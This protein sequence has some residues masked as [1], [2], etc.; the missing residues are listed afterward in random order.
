M[1]YIWI[2]NVALLNVFGLQIQNSVLSNHLVD[3]SHQFL[4]LVGI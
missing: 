3:H 1:E 4:V 2:I